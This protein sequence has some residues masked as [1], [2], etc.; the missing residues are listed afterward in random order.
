MGS[1]V[2]VPPR[3]SKQA[4]VFVLEAIEVYALPL[5]EKTSNI[6]TKSPSMNSFPHYISLQCL[7][8]TWK[9]KN[10]NEYL[11][12]QANMETIKYI[13]ITERKSHT[14][15]TVHSVN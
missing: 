8:L 5:T 14:L 6:T 13:S 2:S 12:N 3:D 10:Y 1:G 4:M 11:R 15:R 9:E 7:I